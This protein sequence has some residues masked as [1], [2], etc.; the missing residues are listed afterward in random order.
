MKI[1]ELAKRTGVSA[2]TIRFWL[3]EGLI[4]AA[5]RTESGYQLFDDSAIARI[6]H[7]RK[8]QEKRLTIEEIREHIAKDAD[9]KSGS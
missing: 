3:G 5:R 8:L 2:S 4:T 9:T 7:I 1:G 6:R